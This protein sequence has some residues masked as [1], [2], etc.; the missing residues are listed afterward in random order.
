MRKLAMCFGVIILICFNANAFDM[1][2]EISI[3]SGYSWR[4]LQINDAAVF[5]PSVMFS[6]GNFW[7]EVWGNMD[8]TNVNDDQYHM[9]EVDITIG[10]DWE[11]SKVTMSTGAIHYTYPGSEEAA[12]T[13]LFA[14]VLFDIPLSPAF[15]MYH[16]VDQFEGTFIEFSISHSFQVFSEDFSDGLTFTAMIGYGSADFKNGY[17]MM[18][19]E[20]AES[21][22]S[23]VVKASDNEH[24]GQL[25]A[26]SGL[27]DYGL[28]LELPLHIRR[29]ALTF[30]LE[31]YNLADSDIHS[32]GFETEDTHF[33]YGIRYSFSF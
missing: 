5:Q 2:G 16:D 32:P 29:G 33:I 11:F 31:Y 15:T 24:S 17:F 20:I 26:S 30:S 3:R 6:S 9:N 25:E 7:A 28:I 19:S 23:T 21:I 14:G 13:E 1:K 18:K 8:L 12:T 4:G 22:P 27:S 10:Y